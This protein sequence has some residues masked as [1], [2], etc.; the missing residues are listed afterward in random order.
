VSWTF[1]AEVTGRRKVE[2]GDLS[3]WVGAGVAGAAIAVWQGGTP[4]IK[5]GSREA[6]DDAPQARDEA[7]TPIFSVTDAQWIW[8]R[9]GERFVTATIT[10]E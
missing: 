8:G 2:I 7:A 1:G 4:E 10:M 6:L 9:V 5:H 3:S